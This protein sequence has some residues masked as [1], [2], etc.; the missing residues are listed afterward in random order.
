MNTTTEAHK[1]ALN[2]LISI[3]KEQGYL[4]YSEINN[5]LPDD[6]LTVEK[7][8]PIVTILEEIIETD[9]KINIDALLRSVKTKYAENKETREAINNLNESKLIKLTL[10]KRNSAAHADHSGL[11]KD[12][13]EEDV[14]IMAKDLEIILFYLS[15]IHET[16]MAIEVNK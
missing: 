4:T 16:I 13:T 8:E 5:L 6:L 12:F 9:I 1:K 3:G 15:N 10:E 2:S 7:V 14:K 11:K